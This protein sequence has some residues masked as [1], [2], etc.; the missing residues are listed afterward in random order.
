MQEGWC[1]IYSMF[2]HVLYAHV[3]LRSHASLHSC[4][5]CVAEYAWKLGI[6]CYICKGW[7][8]AA[9]C[10]S[11]WIQ[12]GS[13]EIICSGWLI[14]REWISLDGSQI[15]PLQVDKCTWLQETLRKKSTA[16]SNGNFTKEI[17]ASL[18]DLA[19]ISSLGP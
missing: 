5:I 2:L 9:L 11:G 1:W 10:Q 7:I 18:K 13:F 3:C 16:S 4:L 17:G 14:A 15:L 12:L 6:L 19:Y 8:S